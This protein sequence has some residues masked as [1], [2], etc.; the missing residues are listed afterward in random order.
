MVA[1][2]LN[3]GRVPAAVALTLGL[4]KAATVRHVFVISKILTSII[5]GKAIVCGLVQLVAYKR[6]R[7][8]AEIARLYV[9]TRLSVWR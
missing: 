9:C 6:R 5:A 2:S 1:V 4:K 3:Q 7:H 8:V